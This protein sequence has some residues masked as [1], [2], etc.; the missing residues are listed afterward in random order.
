[1]TAAAF[2]FPLA[3]RK[4]IAPPARWTK[5]QGVDI[6]APPLDPLLA[7]RAGTIVREGIGGFGPWAPILHFDQPLTVNGHTYSYAYYGHAGPDLVPVGAHVAQGQPISEVGAGRVGIS[8]GPHLEFGLSSSEAIPATG[9]TSSDA[10]SALAGGLAGGKVIGTIGKGPPAGT[11]TP[12]PSAIDSVTGAIGSVFSSFFDWLKG[13]LLR[14]ALYAVLVIGGVALAVF[15]VTRL[16]ANRD[17]PAAGRP[18]PI[19]IPL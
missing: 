9:A 18:V 5:D 2:T 12:F 10:L 13:S 4:G 16:F 6:A 8:T 11:I 7:V 15:G 3:S 14:G 1:M 17:R 19:P